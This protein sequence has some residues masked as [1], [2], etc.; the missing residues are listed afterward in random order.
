GRENS[1]GYALDAAGRPTTDPTAGLGGVV[2]PIGGYKGSGPSMLMDILGGVISGGDFGGEVGDQYKAYARPRD[3]GHFFR[4]MRPDLFVPADE[5][6]QRMDTLI[7]RVHAAPTA[8]GCDEVLV[9]GEPELR[10]EAER[11]KRGIPYSAG[12]V[13]ALQEEAA[14][15]GVPA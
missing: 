13:A 15:A 7:K 2:L 8:E 1:L 3:A 5:Y 9:A 4:G 10:H 11:R 14:K 6:R 12:E